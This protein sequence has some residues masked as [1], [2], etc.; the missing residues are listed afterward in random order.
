M[1]QLLDGPDALQ[2]VT[3]TVRTAWVDG[4]P[5][6]KIDG[7]VGDPILDLKCTDALVLAMQLIDQ[8]GRAL[9]A[10]SAQPWPS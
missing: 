10:R 7:L 1:A 8:G 5:F 3:P 6:I 2:D 9:A 4:V